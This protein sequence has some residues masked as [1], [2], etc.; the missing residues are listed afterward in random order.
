MT[1]VIDADGHVAEPSVVWTEYTE[2]A[3]RDRVIQ[4]RPSA[5]F[6]PQARLALMD[7]EGIDVAVLYPTLWLLYGDIHDPR[8]AAAACRA[9][10]DWIADFCRA[11]PRRLFAVAPMPIQSVE[12]AV[13]EMRR[14]VEK[15]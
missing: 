8:V 1:R 15:L 2:P 13:R 12:E 3:F 4:I 6:D 5:A 10:D 9:Y 7:E 14:V 11:D